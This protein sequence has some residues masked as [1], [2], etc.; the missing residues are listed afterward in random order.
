MNSQ[1]VI[2]DFD[3]DTLAGWWSGD[4]A[5]YLLSPVENQL[6]VTINGAGPGWQVFGK[7]L[8][9]T[10]FSSTPVLKISVKSNESV[11]PNIR[12]DLVDSQGL[13][14]NADPVIV[15]PELDGQYH[16]YTM[17]FEGRFQQSWPDW[18][19]VNSSDIT[20]INIFIN[21]GGAEYSGLLYFDNLTREAPSTI[22]DDFDDGDSEGWWSGA[23]GIIDLWN[24]GNELTVSANGAGPGWETFGYSFAPLDFSSHS[25]VKLSVQTLD[26]PPEI[27][28][29]LRDSNGLSTNAY[30]VTVIPANDGITHDYYFNFTDSFWQG[31]P[32][33]VE[34]NSSS[35]T[36]FVFF[37]NPGG[38]S[39][40]GTIILDN[41]S[42][43][44]PNGN[45]VPSIYD[46][47]D[48]NS[49]LAYW[50]GITSPVSNPNIS[51]I[52]YSSN[53]AQYDKPEGAFQVF[54]GGFS[55]NQDFTSKHIIVLDVVGEINIDFALVLQYNDGYG[56]TEDRITAYSPY[57]GSNSWEKLTFDFSD[58]IN[59]TDINSF[60]FLVNTPEDVAT[61]FYFDNFSVESNNDNTN[62]EPEI[63]TG[64]INEDTFVNVADVVLMI[65]V[66]L[67]PDV[68]IITDNQFTA[69]DI[70]G[71]GV[72]NVTDVVNVVGIILGGNAKVT[73]LEYADIIINQNMISVDSK[74]GIAG[75][76][77]ETSGKY[78]I[79][80]E[81]ILPGWI[82]ASDN[83]KI[84]LYNLKGFQ[85]ETGNI[86]AFEGELKINSAIATNW[87]SKSI[88]MDILGNRENMQFLL[89]DSYPNPFNPITSLKFYLPEEGK[90]SI[91]VY[92]IKG[93]LVENII[94]NQNFISGYHST[95]WNANQYSSGIYFT[96]IILNDKSLTHKMTLVK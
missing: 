92:D 47:F 42:R 2:D 22:I 91:I 29:D 27:R 68:N 69:A 5:A 80:E 73:N 63:I 82:L 78:K 7:S 18:V 51:G 45:A 10:D 62:P 89:L 38:S 49:N 83:D 54:G 43:E 84:I 14:T 9:T 64:D 56:N 90:L 85:I 30:P 4:P 58:A 72:I 21:A 76:Q 93:N 37:L 79:N 77:I 61:T 70:N 41:I 35:I 87:N 31:W 23:P 59:I 32:D 74:G 88:D 86:F 20:G 50:W 16:V 33:W 13:T 94:S 81:S 52:N 12:V 65:G 8:E 67:N 53:V 26:S 96:T 95:S 36:E 48:S 75:I 17:N 3:A 40:T 11:A 15:I 34:V 39:F 46:N 6:E 55:G 71:D 28:L 24:S 1:I 44:N 60:V 57:S 19:E 66:I 25:V